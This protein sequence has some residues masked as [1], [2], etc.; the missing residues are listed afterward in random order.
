[1]NRRAG[2]S[3]RY[4][5]C[6]LPCSQLMVGKA[7]FGLQE[8]STA[9]PSIHAGAYPLADD[10]QGLQNRFFIRRILF[11]SSV[12]PHVKG[13]PCRF[14]SPSQNLLYDTPFTLANSAFRDEFSRGAV[15]T[16][17]CGP[18]PPKALPY[19]LIAVSATTARSIKI[20]PSRGGLQRGKGLSGEGPQKE[21]ADNI[22][23]FFR[24][25]FSQKGQATT[26][27]SPGLHDTGGGAAGGTC[28]TGSYPS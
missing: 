5:G 14:P 18:N 23:P 26:I 3:L 28:C 16:S 4:T 25:S 27:R 21:R 19:C 8:P 2:R 12:P 20:G 9:E 1:M 22:R 17:L 10:E 6:E 11:S 7:P 13:K 24:R 15:M